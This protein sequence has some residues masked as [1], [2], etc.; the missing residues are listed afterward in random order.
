MTEQQRPAWAAR[1]GAER[2]ARGWGKFAMARHLLAA[3]GIAP[4]PQKVKTL[5][6][7]ILGWEKGSHFPRDWAAAYSAA[8]DI[9]EDELF[10]APPH[11]RPA[12]PVGTVDQSPT[13]DQGDDDVK[14]RAALQLITALGAGAAVPPGV[15]ETIFAG[16]EDALGDPIDLAEWEATVHEYG[17]LLIT[18]PNGT[19]ISALTADIIAVGELLRRHRGSPD[20][21]GLLRISAGLSG[22]LAI[23]LGDVG[24]KRAARAS[25]SIAKRAADASGDRDLRVWVRGRAAQDAVWAGRPSAVVTDLTNA[26]IG[27][28]AGAPSAGLAR[29]HAAHA[30]L[31][32]DQGDAGRA[33]ESLGALKRA[34]D[35]LPDAPDDQSVLAY[36]ESQLRWA[37]SY[38]HTRAGDRRAATTLTQAGALYPSDALGPVVNLSLMRAILMIKAREIDSGLETA[39]APLRSRPVTVAGGTSQLVRQIL[40]ALP[41]QARA[42]PAA[43]E[44]QALTARARP[45]STTT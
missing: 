39:L 10:P 35:R 20:A 27:I 9:P 21:S 40:R 5:T 41:D 19:L 17:Q 23:D 18:Q 36:R 4:S 29:A 6:R 44:L 13:P 1:L 22:L 15:L 38:V 45:Q 24:D 26:A 25:W 30:Y 43:R 34:F 33:H 12:T 8:F 37:E 2:E 7:Q 32:A 42:L 11:G 31:A 16:I 3:V 14:R 28:A